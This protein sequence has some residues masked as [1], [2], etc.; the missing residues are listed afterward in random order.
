MVTSSVRLSRCSRISHALPA[1]PAAPS[2]RHRA[3]VATA[4]EVAR[5]RLRRGYRLEAAHLLDRC[6][7]ALAKDRIDDQLLAERWA[8]AHDR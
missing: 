5:R 2:E 3:P 8:Y 6:V 1:P 4:I 7:Q